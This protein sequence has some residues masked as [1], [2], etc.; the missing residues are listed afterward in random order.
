MFRKTLV[1]FVIFS[2]FSLLVFTSCSKDESSGSSSSSNKN[3]PNDPGLYQPGKL[4]V[5]TGEPVYPPW[6]MDD[7]PAGGA[8][9]E[10]GMV[11]ALAAKLGYPAVMSLRTFPLKIW[12]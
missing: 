5:A 12:V 4:T 3:T 1:F 9:F 10:N 6:M 11:Y 7:N 8:G 2:L